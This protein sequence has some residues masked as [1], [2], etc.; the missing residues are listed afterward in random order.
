MFRDSAKKRILD[1]RFAMK[2]RDPMSESSRDAWILSGVRVDFPPECPACGGAP[3]DSPL[4]LQGLAAW[5]HC[6][7]CAASQRRRLRTDRALVVA[8]VVGMVLA[9]LSA[10][11]R[12]RNTD[13]GLEHAIWLTGVSGLVLIGSSILLGLLLWINGRLR[14]VVGVRVVR[15]IWEG[16]SRAVRIRFR[17]PDYRDALL[18]GNPYASASSL[19]AIRAAGRGEAVLPSVRGPDEQRRLDVYKGGTRDWWTD[20]WRMSG[21]FSILMILFSSAAFVAAAG[22]S[23]RG[24]TANH[25]TVVLIWSSVS[26]LASVG[27]LLKFEFARR[28]A[29]LHAVILTGVCTGALALE[30][31]M[32]IRGPAWWKL[33]LLSAAL[34]YFARSLN[35]PETRRMCRPWGILRR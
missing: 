3:A 28:V 6:R 31:W 21:V 24:F 23:G 29:A 33:A 19:G 1:A 26:L 14:P 17:R 22:R 13:R 12:S 18:K 34:W 7:R 4:Q 16:D 9:G 8:F 15:V 20:S 25:P 10:L 2:P 35:A 30:L 32:P 5:P 11:A 27:V